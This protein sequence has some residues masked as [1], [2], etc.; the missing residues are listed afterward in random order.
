MRQVVLFP[1]MGGKQVP[2]KESDF[3]FKVP[4][5]SL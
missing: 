4:E 1:F 3:F 2:E 5:Y